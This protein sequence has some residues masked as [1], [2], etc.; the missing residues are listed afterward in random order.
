MTTS[1]KH[2]ERNTFCKC[3]IFENVILEKK[4]AIVEDSGC[5]RDTRAHYCGKYHKLP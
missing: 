4:T 1:D 5:L 2:F 3:R